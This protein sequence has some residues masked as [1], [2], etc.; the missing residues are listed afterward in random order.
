MFWDLFI[1][2]FLAFLVFIGWYTGLS[3]KWY[4]VP[5]AVAVA[6]FVCQHIYVDCATFMA[7]FLH[8]EPFVAVFLAYLLI[9]M[10]LEQSCESVLSRFKAGQPREPILIDKFS[11]ASVS[12]AKG[13][14]GFV[15]AAMV[16][17]SHSHVPNPP[18]LGWEDRWLAGSVKHSQLLT[19]LHKLAGS[20][21]DVLGKY[22][23]SDAAPRFV[24]NFSGEPYDPFI[25]VEKAEEEHG[26]DVY[27]KYKQ[28]K[29]E[30]D[31]ISF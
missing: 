10:V 19:S 23:L 21:H 28:F 13:V 3:R 5:I 1:F 2:F 24:P 4:A 17:Y 15:C 31:N 9:W 12:L 11:G 25:N 26:K 16:A 30:T 22:V 29:D 18:M 8:L 7:E 14:L 20:S 27:R 6:I